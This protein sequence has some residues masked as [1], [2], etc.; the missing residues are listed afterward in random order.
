MQLSEKCESAS[1]CLQGLGATG[2]PS[3]LIR[4]TGLFIHSFLTEGYVYVVLF[5]WMWAM[6]AH[7]PRW[8]AACNYGRW[9]SQPSWGAR[10]RS[11]RRHLAPHWDSP[12]HSQHLVPVSLLS[13]ERDQRLLLLPLCCPHGQPPSSRAEQPCSAAW[14]LGTAGAQLQSTLQLALGHLLSVVWLASLHT[15]ALHLWNCP[16]QADYIT[17][18]YMQ[19]WVDST[20]FSITPMAFGSL[21]SVLAL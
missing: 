16:S 2:V 17:H 19:F 4:Q 12:C 7:S 6:F 11:P 3:L 1:L 21:K 5:K 18:I 15:G 8:F 13:S 20:V 9:H 10:S 14:A